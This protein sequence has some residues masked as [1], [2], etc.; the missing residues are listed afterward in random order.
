MTKE[1]SL[2]GDEPSRLRM[3]MDT[4]YPLTRWIPALNGE[5]LVGKKKPVELFS[6]KELYPPGL[7]EPGMGVRNPYPQT[8]IPARTLDPTS[9]LH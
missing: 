7:P 5:G 9:H 4:R 1:S 6:G 3:T 8:R 2:I